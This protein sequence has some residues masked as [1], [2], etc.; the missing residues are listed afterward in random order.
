MIEY[1]AQAIETCKPFVAK[2]DIRYYLNGV[3]LYVVD[4]KVVTVAATDGYTMA[5]IGD[6][7]AARTATCVVVANENIPTLL[8]AVASP[9]DTSVTVNDNCTISIGQY[10]IPT[11]DG[12]FPDIT[13]VIPQATRKPSIDFG[14]VLDTG[15]L[16]RLEKARK[17]L[18]SHLAARD[19]KF[20]GVTCKFGGPTTPVTTST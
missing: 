6:D 12:R 17:T 2:G 19:R 3:A 20:I 1:L 5:M 18:T 9:G 16:A 4:G 13:R 10:T 8:I 7:K 14:I 11:V 15:Y